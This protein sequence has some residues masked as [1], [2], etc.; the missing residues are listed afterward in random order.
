MAVTTTTDASDPWV[1]KDI[2]RG[3]RYVYALV[4]LFPLLIFLWLVCGPLFRF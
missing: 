1:D 2:R 4:L 3:K